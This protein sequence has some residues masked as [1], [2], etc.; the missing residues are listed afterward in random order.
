MEYPMRADLKVG[1]RFPDFAL[2]DQSKRQWQLSEI[3]GGFPG[4]LLFIRGSF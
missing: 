1:S 4:V 2:P 3:L